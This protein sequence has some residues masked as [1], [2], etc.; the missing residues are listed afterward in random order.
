MHVFLLL[1]AIVTRHSFEAQVG[2]FLLTR[3]CGG[4]A[5]LSAWLRCA[6]PMPTLLL[7]D[8]AGAVTVGLTA[9]AEWLNA[10][11]AAHWQ[12]FASQ[13]YF[14]VRALAPLLL[15]VGVSRCC[16]GALYLMSL[17]IGLWRAAQE[18]GV[19]ASV[20]FCAPLLLV[21][22]VILVLSLRSTV[23]MMVVTKR[24][25]LQR[26]IRAKKEI[27]GRT[28]Q[29]EEKEEQGS[30]GQPPAAAAPSGTTEAS[31][32]GKGA[33]G[34][35]DRGRG[36]GVTARAAAAGD[37]KGPSTRRRKKPD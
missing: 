17:H 22:F 13:D 15:C 33:V 14:D 9:S 19:F 6:M 35:A 24:H 23:Q 11:G 18:H 10:W 5:A 3:A 20:V 7:T 31:G 1:A 36:R 26:S 32:A 30:G 37:K 21:A 2:L 8:R 4:A 29:E 16:C 34:T 25:E 28:E 27:K 12:E